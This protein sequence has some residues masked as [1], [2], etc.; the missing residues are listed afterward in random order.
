MN[1]DI[2]V[3]LTKNY[4]KKQKPKPFIPGSTYI[5]SSGQYFDEND[6]SALVE[7]ALGQWYAEGKYAKTFEKDLRTFYNTSYIRHVVLANSGSSANLLA[8]TA[9]TDKTFGSRRAQPGD[10]IITVGVGF[11]TTINPII[12]NGLVPV[13][14]DVDLNTLCPDM[15]VIENAIVEGKTK[16]II[17]AHPL[18]NPFDVEQLRDICT[19]YG[20]WLIED[21][22][23]VANTLIPTK[24]GTKHISDIVVGDK[25]LGFDGTSFKE[26]EVVATGNHLVHQDD[27]IAIYFEN[28]QTVRCTKNHPFFVRGEWIKAGDLVEGDEVYHAT[29]SEYVSWR[30]KPRQYSEEGLRNLS[31]GMKNNNPM[32]NPEIVKKSSSNRKSGMSN[33]EKRVLQTIQEFRLPIQYTGDFTFWI[34]DDESGYKNPDFFFEDKNIVFEVYDPTFLYEKGY[35][36]NV[37]E[38]EK[39]KH[40]SKF[41]YKVVFIPLHGWVGIKEREE[42]AKFLRTSISN[43]IRI[44]RIVP[45]RNP[46]KLNLEREPKEY[47][48][49][50]NIKCAPHPNFCLTGGILVHNCDGLGGSFNGKLL[51]SLGDISTLSFYPAHHI[52]AGEGGACIVQSPQVEKVLKSYRD[53]GKSCWCEPG[54]DNTCGKRFCW[55]E[56]ELPEG[57]DHKYT[58]SRIGY[59]LKATDLQ[60]SLLTSQLKKLPFFIE[61]RRHNWRIL[62]EGLDKYKKYFRFMQPLKGANP[63]WFGFMIGVKESAPFTRRELI[64]FLENRKIGTR[65]VFAGNALRQP[66]YADI[67]CKVFQPLVNSDVVMNQN[68]WIGVHPSI[69]DEMLAYM[70]STFDEFIE[71]HL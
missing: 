1:S 21:N 30:R 24:D 68:F 37:W 46:N 58:F 40:Y 41:G 17:I 71:K 16:G 55:K 33:L 8:V 18:G 67:Q 14:V 51:G 25:V 56:G 15:D 32:Y 45:V 28:G 22:C 53:W 34:G 60:A 36:D 47:V 10:E 11:P 42:L 23:F 69:T 65:L 7:C 2:I 61:K 39:E 63:S 13:F 52:T 9:I 59:N 19:E 62:R 70:L 27:V 5:T 54:Q 6:V 43:G 4:I 20:I 48:R 12:Q 66:A 3:E 50:Y 38:Q 26:T 64:D 57:Y 49:V 35:R 31:D 44:E 29:W